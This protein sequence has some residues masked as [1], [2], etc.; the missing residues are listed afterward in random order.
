MTDAAGPGQ[1]A[2]ARGPSKEP[3]APLARCV[4]RTGRR[5]HGKYTEAPL[6]PVHST[7]EPLTH[8]IEYIL[9]VTGL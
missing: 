7:V 6:P 8:V 3:R 4:V 1:R 2:G 5:D 9:W